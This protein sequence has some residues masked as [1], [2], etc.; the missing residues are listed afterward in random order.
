[1]KS[2]SFWQARRLLLKIFSPFRVRLGFIARTSDRAR[3][4]WE[5]SFRRGELLHPIAFAESP[6]LLEPRFLVPHSF[7]E[8][9]VWIIRGGV[10]DFSQGVVYLKGA[11]VA[12]STSWHSSKRIRLRP[13]QLAGARRAHA[14][15]PVASV[16]Q[17]RWNYYHWLIEDLPPLLY[18]HRTIP[19]LTVYVGKDA[20]TFVI[21]SLNFYGVDFRMATGL[22]RFPELAFVGRG[23]DTGWPH[24]WDI[25]QVRVDGPAIR[26]GRKVYISRRHSSRSPQHEADLEFWLA[27]RGFEIFFLEALSF[28]GQIQLLSETSILVAQHGAGLANLVFAPKG[29]KVVEIFER[30]NVN[31]CFERLSG[32]CGHVHQGV[33]FDR[34]EDEASLIEKVRK[35]L[36]TTEV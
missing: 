27:Q 1:M 14:R 31:Q 18:L 19:D 22:L 8:R 28:E 23:N 26:Q 12:E 5:D 3:H 30:G 20:P 7:L 13:I 36:E 32:I 21:N 24:P 16:S 9:H 17:H 29:I 2:R 25:E 35:V 15:G 10:F 4:G 6:D 34:H 33:V 11:G